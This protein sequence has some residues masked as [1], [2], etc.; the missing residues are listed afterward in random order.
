MLTPKHLGLF[1]LPR[2]FLRG[3]DP[4]VEAFKSKTGQNQ[5]TP[6]TNK[7]KNENKSKQTKK[8]RQTKSPLGEACTTVG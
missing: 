1:Q 4:L 2:D 3:H 7:H 8:P 5:K 6:T